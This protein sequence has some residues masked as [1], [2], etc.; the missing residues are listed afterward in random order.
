MRDFYLQASYNQL[1]VRTTVIGPYTVSHNMAYYGADK[2]GYKDTLKMALA[3]E[4][5]MMIKDDIDLSQFD[6]NNDG[7]VECVHILYAGQGQDNNVS[8]D[9]IWPHRSSISN[10]VD[11]IG[12]KMSQYMMTPELSGFYY[13]GI[14]TACH[15]LGHI[16]ISL[17]FKWKIYKIII[18]PFGG[19]TKYNEIIN[20]P[21][22]EE[23]LVSISG[24]LL[25]L[26]FFY[27]HQLSFYH[28]CIKPIYP[29]K[30]GTSFCSKAYLP[31]QE[32][33]SLFFPTLDKGL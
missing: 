32:S 4:V 23:F 31:F 27:L 8:T 25:Q 11:G 29:T 10:Y 28:L 33:I 7:W 24:I 22:I 12:A 30:S 16:L 15:E 18:L 17:L 20:R 2:N 19:L 26:I 21:L 13:R 3:Q 14:G 1:D 9:V 6:N 5:M